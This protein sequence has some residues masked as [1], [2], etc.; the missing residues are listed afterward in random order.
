MVLIGA[1]GF[2]CSIAAPLIKAGRLPNITDLISRG[3]IG[4]MQTITP[5]KSPIIWTTIAT[6]VRK[7]KH[8]IRGFIVKDGR[9]KA[10]AKQRQNIDAST[11]EEQADTR[12][13][14]RSTNRKV[15][16]LWNIAGEAGRRVARSPSSWSMPASSP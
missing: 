10:K 3:V 5:T 16:A 1:D 8:G 6:G 12:E 15:K 11:D 14:V 9:A 4:T 2:D 13:L 7:R